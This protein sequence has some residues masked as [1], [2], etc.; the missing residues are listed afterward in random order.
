M[1]IRL[2][3]N[4][5]FEDRPMR[6][7]FILG[8]RDPEMLE[9]MRVLDAQG[10]PHA[11]ATIRGAPV[12][13]CEAYDATG[14]DGL[15]PKDHKIVFVECDV[16]GLRPDDICDH[17][18]EGDPGYGLPPERYMEG[19]SLGQVLTLLGLE[20]TPEQRVIAAADHCLRH[21]YAGLCPGVDPKALADWRER[22]RAEMRGISVEEL[23]ERIETAMQALRD[24]PRIIV[25]GEEVAWFPDAVPEETP[26]ASARLGIPFCYARRDGGRAKAGIMSAAP[27]VIRAWMRECGL[28]QVYGDPARGFAGGYL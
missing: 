14:I 16:M 3:D 25:G 2:E 5:I 28:N 10:H 4:E 27:N 6:Y 26:E 12:R 24:A 18:N 23:R 19:S 13:S 17:H 22:S 21:A 15:L 11:L 20:P 9:I 1:A 8:A 7:F